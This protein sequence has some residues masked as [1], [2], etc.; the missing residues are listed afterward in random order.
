MWMCFPVL[1]SILPDLFFVHLILLCQETQILPWQWS[2]ARSFPPE[3]SRADRIDLASLG[4][5]FYDCGNV[6]FAV[7]RGQ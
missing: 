7:F 2:G 4:L 5:G 1:K 3:R 6:S